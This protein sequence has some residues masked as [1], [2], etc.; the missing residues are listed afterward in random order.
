M[1]IVH[2][3]VNTI[4]FEMRLALNK[5]VHPLHSRKGPEPPALNVHVLTFLHHGTVIEGS[6]QPGTNH[7]RA[8]QP[9]LHPGESFT[10]LSTKS[11]LIDEFRAFLPQYPL[12]Q[13][14]IQIHRIYH[15]KHPI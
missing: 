3:C 2:G 15:S 11:A 8:M 9:D 7:T 14:T 6:R 5:A 10:A 1:I 12:S 4:Y 13:S